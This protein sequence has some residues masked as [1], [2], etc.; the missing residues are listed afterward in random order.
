[1]WVLTYSFRVT[2]QTNQTGPNEN[3]TEL[4]NSNE[5]FVAFLNKIAKF[6]VHSGGILNNSLTNF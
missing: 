4:L 2:N 3:L 6:R 1:M 5:I